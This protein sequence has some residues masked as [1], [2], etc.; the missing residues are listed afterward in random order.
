M[1]ETA[2]LVMVDGDSSEFEPKEMWEKE[3]LGTR[4]SSLSCATVVMHRRTQAVPH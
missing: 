4:T 2:A 3:H 1:A